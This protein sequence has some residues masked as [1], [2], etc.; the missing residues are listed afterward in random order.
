MA[1][2]ERGKGKR[3]QMIEILQR[4]AVVCMQETVSGDKRLPGYRRITDE[5]SARAVLIAEV[6]AYLEDGMQ[7]ADDEA[8]T[9]AQSVLQLKE[10]GPQ[11]LPLRRD[12]EIYN[13]ATGFVITSRKMAGRALD[14]GSAEWKEAVMKGEMLPLTLVQDDPFVIRVVAG[15]SLMP[16]EEE[17]WVSRV[18]WQLNIP[19][20]NLCITGGSVF[21]NED[22]EEGDSGRWRF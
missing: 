15:D 20:G 21:T 4:G 14:E 11:A 7:P 10:P 22:Y 5:A 16:Q 8:R 2:L 13:E 12:L 1:M 9:I 17:E 18:D 3:K 19:D 6:A